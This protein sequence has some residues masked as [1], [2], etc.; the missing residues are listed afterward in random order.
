[1]KQRNVNQNKHKSRFNGTNKTRQP[2]KTFYAIVKRDKTERV[3]TYN[4]Y[5]RIKAKN[6]LQKVTDKHNYEITYFG[7]L[8]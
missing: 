1:M 2:V 4:S 8:Q 7:V 6:H 5:S 3:F